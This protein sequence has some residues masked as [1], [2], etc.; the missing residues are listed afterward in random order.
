MFSLSAALDRELTVSLHMKICRLVVCG[1]YSCYRPVLA[2][3]KF[4]CDLARSPWSTTRGSPQICI[5]NTIPLGT[6]K[7]VASLGI[8][9][10]DRSLYQ[11]QLLDPIKVLVHVF[12]AISGPNILPATDLC[13][14]FLQL[15]WTRVPA[16]SNCDRKVQQGRALVRYLLETFA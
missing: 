12:Q 10:K 11:L 8:F 16:C 15:V 1:V 14:T 6:L 7:G 3:I 5:E 4:A 2:D 13:Q 9:K